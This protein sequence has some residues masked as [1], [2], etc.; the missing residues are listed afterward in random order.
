MKRLENRNPKTDWIITDKN[1]YVIKSG[2][3]S[4]IYKVDDRID[5]T[6]LLIKVVVGILLVYTSWMFRQKDK[7]VTIKVPEYYP[8]EVSK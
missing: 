8:S 2:S 5:I 6:N 3:D 4:S 1:G 7:Q